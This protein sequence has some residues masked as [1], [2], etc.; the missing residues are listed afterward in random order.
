MPQPFKGNWT[1]DFKSLAQR[2][3]L[4]AYVGVISALWTQVDVALGQ[5]LAMMLQAEARA[6]TAMYVA[7]ENEGSKKAALRKVAEERLTK[8]LL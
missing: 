2:P 3:K 7:I 5:L 8:D 4:A 6:V 1:S